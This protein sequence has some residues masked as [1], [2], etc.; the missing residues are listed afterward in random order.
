LVNQIRLVSMKE[1]QRVGGILLEMGKDLFRARERCGWSAC[2]H[3][4]I[5]IALV[6]GGDKGDE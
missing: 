6:S 1:V 3:C 4:C 5:R 2:C